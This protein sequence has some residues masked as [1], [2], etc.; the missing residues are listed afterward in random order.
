MTWENN[1]LFSKLY[2]KCTSL[3]HIWFCSCMKINLSRLVKGIS[4]NHSLFTASF[5]FFNLLILTRVPNILISISSQKTVT[6]SWRV[7][8]FPQN[9]MYCVDVLLGFNDHYEESGHMAL[10]FFCEYWPNFLLLGTPYQIEMESNP[11][12]AKHL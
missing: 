3:F 2:L 9:Y 7:S 8:L 1:S 12:T 6:T 11:T 4:L 10:N 5:F